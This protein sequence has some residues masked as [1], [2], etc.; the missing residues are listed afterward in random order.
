VIREPTLDLSPEQV[1][2]TDR[3]A[4][5][6]RVVQGERSLHVGAESTTAEFPYGLERVGALALEERYEPGAMGDAA[7]SD[8]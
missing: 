1:R 6:E 2:G 5:S 8:V 4:I 3:H 7:V